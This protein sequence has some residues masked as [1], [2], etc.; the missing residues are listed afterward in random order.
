[1]VLEPTPSTLRVRRATPL[2]HATP[3]TN[4]K[5]NIWKV[6]ICVIK[7][8]HVLEEFVFGKTLYLQHCNSAFNKAGDI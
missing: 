6:Y 2:R 3:V 7:A 5:V 8:T 1:M 4:E